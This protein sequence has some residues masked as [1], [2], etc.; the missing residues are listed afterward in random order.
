MHMRLL[1]W[2]G[3]QLSD[4]DASLVI[5]PL[6]DAGAVWAGA[7]EKARDVPLPPVVAASPARAAAAGLVTHLHRDH[8]DAEALAAALAPGA[9]VLVPEP[10]GGTAVE[11]AG[12]AQ[13]AAELAAAGL[14]VEPVAPWASREIDGWSIT[15]LPAA[16]GLGD[17]QLSWLV[18]RDGLTVVHAGD[19]MMH[20]WWW[21][22]AERA[23]A[24]VAAAFLPVNG[25]R[26]TFPHRRPRSQLPVVMNAEEAAI[27]ATILRARR[28]VPIHYG[29]YR[30]PPVYVPDPDPIAA[31]P[32]DPDFEVL[33]PPLGEWRELDAA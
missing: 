22:V 23:P 20:G 21:R 6:A 31:L 3:V 28:L 19:T 7:G 33:T 12:V 26:V 15:A 18:A 9:P 30:F 4:G 11:E 29:A 5:D 13:A 1:G 24:P 14:A 16:D 25:A 17:P 27:A 8:A 2:A 32:P 10:T